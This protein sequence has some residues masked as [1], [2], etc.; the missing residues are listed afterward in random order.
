[1]IYFQLKKKSN[2]E[3]SSNGIKRELWA[4]A[5][6]YLLSAVKLTNNRVEK[7]LVF[8]SGKSHRLMNTISYWFPSMLWG[9]IFEQANLCS[10]KAFSSLRVLRYSAFR[11]LLY[12]PFFLSWYLKMEDNMRNKRKQDG[13]R[14]KLGQICRWYSSVSVLEALLPLFLYEINRTCWK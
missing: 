6:N 8:L 14:H 13:V 12:L 5:Y 3:F 4:E 9:L 1:M 2:G 10:V 7:K 11:S